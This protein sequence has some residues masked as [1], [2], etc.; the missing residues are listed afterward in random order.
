MKIE[1]TDA[2][3][4]HEHGEIT[5]EE[6]VALSGMSS[7]FLHQLIDHGALAPIDQPTHSN[8]DP[9]QWRFTTRC[10]VTV[11][12]VNRLR[13]DFDLDANALS[14][15]FALLERLHDLEMRLHE[16]QMQRPR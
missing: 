7:E 11:R 9:A 15:A 8:L 4:L 13:Q 12:K 16:L 14:V 1:L 5:F 3:W 6:V 2:E 10:V